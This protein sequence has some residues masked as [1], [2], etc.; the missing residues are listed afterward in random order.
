MGSAQEANETLT[1][2]ECSRRVCLGMQQAGVRT[3]QM[4]TDGTMSNQNPSIWHAA[5]AAPPQTLAAAKTLLCASGV[6]STSAQ[7]A[8]PFP[9]MAAAAMPPPPAAA[10]AMGGFAMGML[11]PPPATAMDVF[12]ASM[13]ELPE[14]MSAPVPLGASSFFAAPGMGGMP[15]PMIQQQSATKNVL[16]EDFISQGQV[17]RMMQKLRVQSKAA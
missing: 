2:E 7:M 17:S 10:A 9:T 15:A 3:M 12:S 16:T 8:P 4:Q 1:D 14:M 13:P 6:R 11:L 5:G